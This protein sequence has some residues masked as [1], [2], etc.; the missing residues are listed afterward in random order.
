M[1]HHPANFR[2]DP[3]K[4]GE[5]KM[6]RTQEE[7]VY[8]CDVS[9]SPCLSKT[10]PVYDPFTFFKFLGS[11]REHSLINE[12]YSLSPPVNAIALVHL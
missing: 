7:Y 1:A 4:N 2:R 11:I 8:D 12:R 10:G 3:S 5:K 9:G 6:F